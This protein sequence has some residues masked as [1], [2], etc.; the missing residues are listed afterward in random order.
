ML[1]FSFLKTYDLPS[2][3]SWEN[4]EN[5][6]ENSLGFVNKLVRVNYKP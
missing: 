1:N 3:N 5:T 4:Y 2:I 6:Y